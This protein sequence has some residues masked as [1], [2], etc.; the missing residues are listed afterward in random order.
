MSSKA[1][2]LS[3]IH[4]YYSVALLH[5]TDPLSDYKL[6]S[7][8]NFRSK[9]LPDLGICRCINCTGGVIKNEDLGLLKKG[10]GDTQSL[11]LPARNIG[12]ALLYHS[13]VPILHLLYEFIRTC[14]LAGPNAVFFCG[15]LIPPSEVIDDRSGEKNILLKHH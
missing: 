10:S 13:V 4:N 11:P 3:V 7:T 6:G 14:H 15:I 9:C 1:T 2:Y 12:S 5:G 8:G